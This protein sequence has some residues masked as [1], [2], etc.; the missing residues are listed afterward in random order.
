MNPK[1]SPLV[2]FAITTLF[3]LAL[4]VLVAGLAAGCGDPG[5]TTTS[6]TAPKPTSATSSPTRI[7]TLEELARFDGKEG[8]PAYVA[9]D[10]V[11]YDVSESVRWPQG[12]HA[13]CNLGASAGTDLSELIKE[14][15]ANMRPLLERMPV[16][17]T[18][19]P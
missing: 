19:A 18:L 15:P 17:G 10:G 13:P 2:Q 14:A 3:L 12:E 11:V 1:R 6:S 4:T 8:R 9:V 16:V 5:S 7:F